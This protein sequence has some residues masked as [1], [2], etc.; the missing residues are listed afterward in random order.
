MKKVL[1]IIFNNDIKLLYLFSQFYKCKLLDKI[2]PT[3][4][5][6]GGPI[7][8]ILLPLA[9]ITFGKDNTRKCGLEIITSLST[10]HIL[11][12]FIKN[13]FSRPRPYWIIKDICNFNLNLEDYSFP[14]GHTTAAFSVFIILSLYMPHLAI[15]YLTVA[16]LV[17][18][19]RVY[20]GAHY[21][22]DVFVGMLIAFIF[23]FSTHTVFNIYF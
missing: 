6:L 1:N 4:T 16:L 10:S 22:T 14:S 23:S 9:M 5:H 3:I 11:V 19:S 20:L 7:F 12:H 18:I 2:M 15:V 21:P 17:G 13:I 8:T